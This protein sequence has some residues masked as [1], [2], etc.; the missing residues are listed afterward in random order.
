M[1]VQQASEASVL[2]RSSAAWCIA[3]AAYAP[4]TYFIPDSPDPPCLSGA[5]ARAFRG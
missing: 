5:G 2:V 1:L 4:G 3:H